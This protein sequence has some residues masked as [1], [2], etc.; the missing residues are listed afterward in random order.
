MERPSEYIRGILNLEL[1][2]QLG[3]MID[4][5]ASLCM[6]ERGRHP[7]RA[8]EENDAFYG[9]LQGV[10]RG[11]YMDEEGKEGT[12]CFAWE[13]RFFGSECFRTGRPATFSV[14]CL[15]GCACVKLPYSLVRR[16]AEMEARIGDA[17]Q[18]LYLEEL[19]I[20]EVR[21][22]ELLLLPARERYLRFCRAYP[23]LLDRVPLKDA[24]SYLGIA[25]GSVS[26]IRK[27]LKELKDPSQM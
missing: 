23:Q 6:L 19:G 9:I 2:P 18:R 24:A 1:S 25:P 14:E 22:G 16:A 17:L 20:L 13:G 26:R 10:V 12:K 3:R 21:T 7:I 5:G 15:T 11:Y 8:G 4:G 27:E